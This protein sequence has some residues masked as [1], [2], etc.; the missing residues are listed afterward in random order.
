MS[1]SVRE[2]GLVVVGDEMTAWL[3]DVPVV[4]EAGGEGEQALADAGH[5]AG[6]RDRA[7]LFEG[8]L[9]LERVEDAL[10]PLADLAEAAEAGL[11]A[12]AVW[13]PED[14][15]QLGHQRFEVLAGEALV[16]D[17]GVALQ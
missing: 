17:N 15:A 8:E 3:A 11:L 10:D 13:A 16:G 4:P 14:R 5:Q 6:H 1:D 2:G 7:V 9:A 12:F